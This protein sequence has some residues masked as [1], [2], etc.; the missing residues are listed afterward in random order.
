MRKREEDGFSEDVILQ[1][2]SQLS[3]QEFASTD[4]QKKDGDRSSPRK[5]KRK[6]TATMMETLDQESELDTSKKEEE[7][8][9][10]T[11]TC[12]NRSTRKQEGN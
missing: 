11:V 7:S 5:R 12:T 9:I 1:E 3:L 10:Q 8:G 2:L 4:I 6:T